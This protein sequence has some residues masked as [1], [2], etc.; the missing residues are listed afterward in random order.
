MYP[1]PEICLLSPKKCKVWLKKCNSKRNG[2][3]IFVS[4]F[5]TNSIG[6]NK[7]S[8]TLS[9]MQSFN[10]DSFCGY[11]WD[12][13]GFSAVY[14]N[15]Y[16]SV[17]WAMIVILLLILIC[18]IRSHAFISVA[19]SQLEKAQIDK[20]VHRNLDLE[21][22]VQLSKTSFLNLIAACH[23]FM[24]FDPSASEFGSECLC[25]S[26][27]KRTWDKANSWFLV[28]S[29]FL[30]LS[31]NKWN[32]STNSCFLSGKSSG[33]TTQHVLTDFLAKVIPQ[34][35]SRFVSTYGL[36]NLL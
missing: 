30:V 35:F 33:H 21:A 6:S 9:T 13:P 16:L 25:F 2:F 14:R 32:Q 22:N 5:E 15:Q 24:C 12:K 26:S 18:L 20:L 7:K 28:L 1:S 3:E 8:E 31:F 27:I 17:V 34:I 19:E 36:R 23:T 10:L 4:G 29:V 11:L